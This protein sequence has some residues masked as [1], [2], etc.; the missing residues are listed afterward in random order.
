MLKQ[1]EQIGALEEVRNYR[2]K[3]ISLSDSHPTL[4][5][6]VHH[7]QIPGLR[8]MLYFMGIY[9]FQ[10]PIFWTG[11]NFVETSKEIGIDLWRRVY[12]NIPDERLEQITRIFP[13]CTIETTTPPIFIVHMGIS[14]SEP[15]NIL[16]K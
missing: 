15:E 5:I 14:I 3:A 8:W 11:A 4:G 1:L 9:Y 7:H 16:S 12:P 13:P 2:C 6:R 10:G